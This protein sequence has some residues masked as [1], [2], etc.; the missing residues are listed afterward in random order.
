M[1][2][3]LIR[4]FVAFGAVLAAVPGQAAPVGP[5]VNGEFEIA[6]EAAKAPMCAA[7]GDTAVNVLPPDADPHIP[8]PLAPG[9][10]VEWPWLV[11]MAPCEAGL[12][13]AAQ[14]SSSR[15]TQ[16]GDVSGDGDR[17]AVIDGSIPADPFLGAD[18]NFWQSYANPQQAYSGNFDAL[19]FRLE[20]GEIPAG[21]YVQISLSATPLETVSPWVGVFFDCS[22]TFTNLTPNE[23][24]VVSVDPATAAFAS[25]YVDCEDAAAAWASAS[26]TG[27]HTILSR[28][29]IV[30]LSF[31]SF[32]TGDPLVLD[33]VELVNGRTI[34]G[35]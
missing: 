34:V 16:F 27:R 31:W 4:S 9:D 6:V 20:G 24:G 26:T 28:L 12:V 1:K 32:Q 33:G 11:S 5:V 25:V 10:D 21:A 23:A 35:I 7:F 17:E 13:K 18:H 8:D 14:W 30:Q 22:L 2:S 3:W 29:R 19:Q 15:V